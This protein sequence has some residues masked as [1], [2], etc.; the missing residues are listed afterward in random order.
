[1]ITDR[2]RMKLFVKILI[3]ILFFSVSGF[4]NAEES[5]VGNIDFVPYQQ[6]KNII[7]YNKAIKSDIKQAR[8]TTNSMKDFT[9]AHER[10][11]QSNVVAAYNEYEKLTRKADNDFMRIILAYEL[12]E[13]G[14]FTLVQ[15]NFNNIDDK[16][17]WNTTMTFIKQMY[18][19]KNMPSKEDEL[20]IAE[21]YTDIYYNNLPFE[22]T[23]T[24]S[25]DNEL[26]KRTD[27]AYFILAQAYLESKE[28]FKAQNT[29]NKA[30]SQN[31]NNLNYKKYKAQ[32][33][34]EDKKYDEAL[35][36]INEVISQSSPSIIAK[37]H[38]IT[39]QNYI[40]AQSKK[41][42]AQSKYYLAKYLFQID[43]TQR[44]IKE[45]NSSIFARK[46]NVDAFNLLGDIYL[47][48]N[49]M[50]KASENYQKAA[51]IKKHDAGTMLGLANVEFYWDD[52]DKAIELYNAVLKKQKNNEEAILNIAIAYAMKKDLKSAKN[53]VNKL[54]SIN[55][56]N[57]KGYYLM[58]FLDKDASEKNLKKAISINPIC[59]DAWS[60]LA[61]IEIEKGNIA[62][63][64]EYLF[65]LEYVSYKNFMYHYCKGLIYQKE[66]NYENAAKEFE[67][68]VNMY[69]DFE[70]A[71]KAMIYAGEKINEKGI[72]GKI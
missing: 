41:D 19:P 56:Y 23:K 35:K 4:A 8:S 38:D 29:I 64:K 32:I 21:Y 31:K 14:Y 54:L 57:Y 25:K 28:I 6:I 12:S 3:L 5:S 45:A 71:R 61:L 33:L 51:K 20:K 24:L 69:K 30:I 43:D 27:Y 26:L 53:W 10:F 62:L 18:F 42:L 48:E 59:L 9:I 52:Y 34:S 66:G 47:S 63:A 22:T 50:F 39:L 17:M 13:K 2:D 65:P 40:Y 72:N 36:T 58:S 67:K 44:A 68:T 55:P 1:M 46:R 60:N 15:D 37:E 7:T 49:N 16:E 70:P 11:Y